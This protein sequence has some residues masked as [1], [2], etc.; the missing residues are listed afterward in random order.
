MLILTLRHVCTPFGRQDVPFADLNEL[1]ALSF[2]LQESVFSRIETG[3]LGA[4]G[5]CRDR[6]VYFR[7]VKIKA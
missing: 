5:F 7:H 1:L 4:W 6:S 3:L 2:K